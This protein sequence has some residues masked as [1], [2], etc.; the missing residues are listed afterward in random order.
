D[1]IDE[2]ALRR[3]QRLFRLFALGDVL[4]GA[5][6]AQTG[7]GGVVF[8]ADIDVYPADFAVRAAPAMLDIEG[9]AGGDGAAQQGDEGGQVAVR[10]VSSE[11]QWPILPMRCA[12]SRWRLVSSAMRRCSSASA[13]AASA[14]ALAW[15]SASSAW[16]C[17]V[18][19]RP[20]PR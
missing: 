7:A 14:S 17:S 11:I 10:R 3:A 8:G 6:Q 18:I 1:R 15:R 2:L 12:A 13:R 20:A 16:T 19:S 9:L 4:G 5:E